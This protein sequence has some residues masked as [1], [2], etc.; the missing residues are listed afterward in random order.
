[1]IPPPGPVHREKGEG[2]RSIPSTIA[3]ARG[4]FCR[5]RR[6][7]S[8]TRSLRSRRSLARARKYRPAARLAGDL[9]IQGV[10][11]SDVGRDALSRSLQKPAESAP[12]PRQQRHLEAEHAQRPHRRRCAHVAPESLVPRRMAC[13]QSF[14][15]RRRSRAPTHRGGRAGRVN[16]PP[17][18]ARRCR[19]TLEDEVSRAPA[20]F[21]RR[22][23]ARPGHELGRRAALASRPTARKCSVA[24]LRAFTRM[25]FTGLFA[26]NQGPP[27]PAQSPRSQRSSWRVASA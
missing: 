5:R 1:M 21:P 6:R 2:G 8:C 27:D 20:P 10:G 4:R 12:H 25:T 7:T 23:C 11:E 14:L 22:T 3:P 26:S 13:Q 24:P 15:L 19:P 9:G 17:N 18:H 16:D